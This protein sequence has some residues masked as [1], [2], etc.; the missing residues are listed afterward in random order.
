MFPGYAA[1]VLLLGL[2]LAGC[3]PERTFP[4]PDPTATRDWSIR[5]TQSGGFAGSHLIIAVDAGG[6]I[7]AEDVRAGR[8]AS[9]P[10]SAKTLQ[11]LDVLLQT[12]DLESRQRRPSACADCFVYE[13]EII[14]RGHT[15]RV[16]ADDVTIEASGATELIRYLIDLRDRLLMA[17]S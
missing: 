12:M 8:R 10:A 9:Q 15:L 13:L 4:P 14:N 11:E 17:A 1:V 7:T 3:G 2:S 5:L 16:E 6:T